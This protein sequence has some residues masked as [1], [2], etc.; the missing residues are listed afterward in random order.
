MTWVAETTTTMKMK[1]MMKM[2]AAICPNT[3]YGAQTMKRPQMTKRK[4]RIKNIQVRLVPVHRR[5][6]QIHLVE[7]PVPVPV[8]GHDKIHEKNRVERGT[9]E[10]IDHAPGIAV[11]VHQIIH[12]QDLAVDPLR[13]IIKD[14]QPADIVAE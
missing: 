5:P 3:I 9:V 13:P 1:M 11:I 14:M 6:A 8:P 12:A 4:K 10:K 7:A 2:V